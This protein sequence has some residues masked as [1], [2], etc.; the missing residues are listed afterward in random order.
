MKDCDIDKFLDG[1]GFRAQKFSG[2]LKKSALHDY[3]VIIMSV[4][5]LNDDEEAAALQDYI[6]GGG[7]VIAA[8]TGWAF[9]AIQP[10]P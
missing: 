3:D 8:M 7:G 2:A 10:G 9:P 4:A 6:S 5:N 1:Q